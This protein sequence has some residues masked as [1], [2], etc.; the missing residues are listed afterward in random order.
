M[1]EV[2]P[3]SSNHV[4]NHGEPDEE[5]AAMLD[6]LAADARS[7]QLRAIAYV[8]V[9]SERAINTNWAGHCDLHDMMAGTNVLNHRLLSN[10]NL[11]ER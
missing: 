3:L 2:V 10:A 9:T 11:D 8:G 1:G 7:G 6:Q 4:L 5:L